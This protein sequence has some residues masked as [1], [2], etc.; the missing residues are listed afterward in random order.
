MSDATLLALQ[1][2]DEIE[3][4]AGI[5]PMP[6]HLVK[7]GTER[8]TFRRGIKPT[9]ELKARFMSESDPPDMSSFEEY[10]L[11]EPFYEIRVWGELVERGSCER[12]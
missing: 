5:A 10:E 3:W 12:F 8:R 1:E 4:V 7:L 9:G 11:P 6:D 2:L